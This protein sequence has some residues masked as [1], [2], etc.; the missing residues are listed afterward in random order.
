MILVAMRKRREMILVEMGSK[1]AVDAATA[2][3]ERGGDDGRRRAA[4]PVASS[5]PRRA[6][7]DDDRDN[8]APARP[9]RPPRGALLSCATVCGRRLRRAR[10]SRRHRERSEPSRARRAPRT[11]C[12]ARLADATRDRGVGPRPRR[13]RYDDGDDDDDPHLGARQP[14]RGGGDVPHDPVCGPVAAVEEDRT[15]RPSGHD[16]QAAPRVVLASRRSARQREPRLRAGLLVEC[17]AGSCGNGQACSR[18][19]LPLFANL[20]FIRC[21]RIMIVL[22]SD[23]VFNQAGQAVSCARPGRGCDLR[24]PKR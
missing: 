6:R 16:S 24:H 13:A 18:G 17:V 7:R 9:S 22:P 23:F 5:S 20:F 1:V 11:T 21:K 15:Q 8:A 14:A 3:S 4:G 19:T 12:R 2:V 10:L